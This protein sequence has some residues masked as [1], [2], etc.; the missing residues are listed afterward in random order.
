MAQ[1]EELPMKGIVAAA[2]AVA[3]VVG[4]STEGFGRVAHQSGVAPP[5]INRPPLRSP[6]GGGM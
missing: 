6:Y 5:V 2:L 1:D 3:C 4:F